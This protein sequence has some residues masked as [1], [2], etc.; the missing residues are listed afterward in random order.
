[1]TGYR[2]ALGAAGLL[3]PAL[4]GCATPMTLVVATPSTLVVLLPDPDTGEIGAATV[5]AEGTTVGLAE[6]GMGTR[7]R[8]G[9]E[10]TVP[11]EI[12]TNEVDRIFG[13]ALEARTLPPLSYLL[14]FDTGSEELTPESLRLVP[15][16]LEQIRGRPLADVTAI[17]HTDGV[18][19][20]ESN[21]DLGMR[22]AVLVRD[23]LVA[24]GLNPTLVEVAS[25]GEGDL[26]VPTAD[27]EPEAR[28]RRVE[29]TIR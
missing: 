8:A 25:H 23:L 13:A 26:L 6:S 14:Y 19:T 3:L 16:I 5:T 2:V 12:P 11:V 27:G 21:A 20:A 17:G 1:M 22:R 29:V 9:S 18:G 15:E 28:N 4:A 10:P 24:N 7:V